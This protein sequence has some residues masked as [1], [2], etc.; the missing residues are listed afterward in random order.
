MLLKGNVLY[1]SVGIMNKIGSFEKIKST[2]KEVNFT[3]DLYMDACIKI[4]ED[5]KK[6]Y[7]IDDDIEL[8]GIARGG[9]PMLVTLSHLLGIRRISII[10]T[11]MSNSDD[12]HDYGKFRYVSDNI[13]SDIKKCILFEDIIYKGVTTDG[14]VNI[15]KERNKNVLAVYSLIIDEG[16]KKIKISNGD[17]NIKYVYE[18][19]Q[20]DWVY[21][22]WETDLRKRSNNV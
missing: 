17:L 1:K 21:F 6:N 12:C 4:A 7:K 22:F 3:Y 13:S 11:K 18:I 10:Q 16:F 19:N 14:V 8:V 2:N 15:L 9:L 5:I 20:D